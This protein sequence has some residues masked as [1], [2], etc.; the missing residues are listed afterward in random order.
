MQAAIYARV[1]TARQAEKDLSIPD[2]LRQC[3]EYCDKRGWRVIYEYI[4]PGASGTDDNRPVLQDMISAATS[5]TKPFDVIVVHSHSRFFRDFVLSGLYERRL[6]KHG[7][8]LVSITQDFGTEPT[9]RFVKHLV[10]AFDEHSSAENA[11]HVRRAMLENAR[12]GFFNGARPPFGYRAAVVE[13]RGEKAKKRLEVEPNEA[14]VVRLIFRLYLHGNGKGPMGLK[15]IVTHLNERGLRTRGGHAFTKSIVEA[16]LRRTSYIGQH[17]YNKSD[18]RRTKSRTSEEWVA[19]PV[20][21][22]IDPDVFVQAQRELAR[23]APAATP[24]RIVNGPAL[25]IGLAK[26]AKCGGGMTLSTGKGGRYRYYACA[27]R[28]LKGTSRCDC[29]NIPMELLDG[30]VLDQLATRVFEPSRLLKNS[31]RDEGFVLPEVATS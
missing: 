11:K 30:L 27:S 14:Q 24:P 25:L 9:G 4:E 7:V 10:N 20:P 6:E 18:R 19:V 1:S 8:T 16:M 28:T 5:R 22:I 15:A 29:R 3:R 23:R 12:Q 31:W 2:Q 13:M 26:C 17:F 21:E